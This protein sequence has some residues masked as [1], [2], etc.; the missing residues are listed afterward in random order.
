MRV[1]TKN[2]PT[3]SVQLPPTRLEAIAPTTCGSSGV[4]KVTEPCSSVNFYKTYKKLCIYTE[5]TKMN[6]LLQ[7]KE[8][9]TRYFKILLLFREIVKREIKTFQPSYCSSLRMEFV[10][11]AAPFL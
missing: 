4:E 2:E 6:Y 8:M 10:N 5:Y 11:T 3:G 9:P 1:L 7:R